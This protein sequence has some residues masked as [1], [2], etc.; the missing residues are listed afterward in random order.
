MTNKAKFRS[1]KVLYKNE[2]GNWVLELW[3]GSTKHPDSVFHMEDWK[4]ADWVDSTDEVMVEGQVPQWLMY[5]ASLLTFPPY[6][7]DLAEFAIK[8]YDEIMGVD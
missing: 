4:M 3:G 1:G 2:E 6:A 5:C 7:R 8:K